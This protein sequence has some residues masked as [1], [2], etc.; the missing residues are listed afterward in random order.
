MK[1]KQRIDI[2]ELGRHLLSERTLKENRIILNEDTSKVI[3]YCINIFL[4]EMKMQN[5]RKEEKEFNYLYNNFM[6]DM[7]DIV[8]RNEEED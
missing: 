7:A 8:D 4:E 1:M 5:Q 2:E 3:A 6:E